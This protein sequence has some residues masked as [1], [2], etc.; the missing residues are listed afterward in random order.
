[1]SPVQVDQRGVEEVG[2]FVGDGRLPTPPLAE[3]TVTIF[4]MAAIVMTGLP[5]RP[6][7]HGVSGRTFKRHAGGTLH[8]LTVVHGRS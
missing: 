5:N 4:G 1:M 7:L 8:R 3:A 2:E 6:Q